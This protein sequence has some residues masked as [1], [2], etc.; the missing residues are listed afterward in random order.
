MTHSNKKSD[1]THSDVWP[2]TRITHRIA[3]PLTLPFL[4]KNN[5]THAYVLHRSYVRHDAFIEQLLSWNLLRSNSQCF[6]LLCPVFDRVCW[7]RMTLWVHDVCKWLYEC[8][9]CANDSMS[10]WR[11]RGPLSLSALYCCLPCLIVLVECK[12]LYER[13]TCANNSMSSWR[14]RGRLSLT[15]KARERSIFFCSRTHSVP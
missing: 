6:V 11:V 12:W 13:V 5:M 9:T 1:M 15:F 8:A 14:V 10:S 4:K 2:M 3:S 7:V